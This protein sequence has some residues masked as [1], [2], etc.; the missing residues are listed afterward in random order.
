MVVTS[1]LEVCTYFKVAFYTKPI[2]I[3]L[4]MIDE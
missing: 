4:T 1:I 2:L 3:D